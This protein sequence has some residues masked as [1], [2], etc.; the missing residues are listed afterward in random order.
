MPDM[1]NRYGTS[2]GLFS[3]GELTNRRYNPSDFFE[4]G[5]NVINSVALSTGNTKNQNLFFLLLQL[6]PVEFFE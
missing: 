2:S 1:Q 4:T 6:T 5:S 3:W